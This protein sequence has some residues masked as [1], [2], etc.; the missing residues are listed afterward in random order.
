MWSVPPAEPPPPRHRARIGLQLLDEAGHVLDVGRGV[1]DNRFIF[2][3]QARDRRHL[4][5]RDRRAVGK[6]RANHD[7][8]TDD[9]LRRVAAGLV[10]ELRQADR[11]AGAGNVGHLHRV[12]DLLV[13]QRALHRAGGLV[14]AAAGCGRRHDLVVGRDG[15]NGECA[16]QNGCQEKVL[17]GVLPFGAAVEADRAL[18]SFVAPRGR[19]T[20]LFG[21]LRTRAAPD[22]CNGNRVEPVTGSTKWQSPPKLAARPPSTIT[23]VFQSS[24]PS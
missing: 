6:D 20:I 13:L 10:D 24:A 8:T 7:V 1:D 9:K 15:R 17:H 11:A 3:G 14:P 4:I 21:K 16:G 23:Q 2:T 22:V 18:I 5:E 12:G 19:T